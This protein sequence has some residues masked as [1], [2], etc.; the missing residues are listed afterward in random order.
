MVALALTDIR[1]ITNLHGRIIESEQTKQSR[2]FGEKMDL[3]AS[4]VTAPDRP[5]RR[6]MAH[7]HCFLPLTTNLCSHLCA[8]P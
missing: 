6:G 3:S 2:A 8:Y 7:A 1:I 4:H 5:R